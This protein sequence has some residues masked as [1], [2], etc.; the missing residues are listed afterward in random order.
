M[1]VVS[2]EPIVSEHLERAISHVAIQR[3]ESFK[4]FVNTFYL[5]SKHVRAIVESPLEM[6]FLIWWAAVHEASNGR[7]DP[8]RI[9]AQS[10]VVLNDQHYRVDFRI[11]PEVLTPEDLP[12]FE[13][14]Q[15]IAVEVDGHAFHE[16]TKEQVQLRDSRDRAL[17][18]AGWRVFHFSFSEFTTE[19]V[20]CVE[21][22]L[23]FAWTQRYRR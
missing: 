23:E 21:E 9:E 6:L 16:R 1:T 7:Y 4:N 8:F 17:L 20:K 3:A 10:E 14:W 18:A 12:A 2:V 15:S 11:V 22:V 5:G 19:P 13:R